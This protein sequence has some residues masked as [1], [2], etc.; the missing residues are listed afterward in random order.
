[1]A[2]VPLKR[3]GG[4]LIVRALRALPPGGLTTILDERD[5]R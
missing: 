2:G 1:M 5:A 4:V 3:A